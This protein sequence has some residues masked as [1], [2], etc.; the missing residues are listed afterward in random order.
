VYAKSCWRGNKKERHTTN[1]RVVQQHGPV[2]HKITLLA[3][4]GTNSPFDI[5]CHYNH[6]PDCAESRKLRSLLVKQMIN[7]L[8]CESGNYEE[9]A[10]AWLSAS[11]STTAPF[12]T[13]KG[14]SIFFEKILDEVEFFLSGDEKYKDD[15]ISLL[16][17]KNVVQTYIVSAISVALSPVLGAS[18]VF[19]APAIA[20]VLVT[21]T[22][23][24]LNA[25][26]AM[27]KENRIATSEKST[28]Q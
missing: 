23:M 2:C 24:G 17:E 13:E 19:L 3:S 5:E 15:R 26:L 4:Y 21:I 20:I 1:N 10:K 6:N 12:G 16:N 22:K 8:Y 11:M 25:W 7:K 9:A 14:H 18:A 28:E 27:R